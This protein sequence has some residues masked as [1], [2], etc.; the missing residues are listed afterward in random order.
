MFLLGRNCDRRVYRMSHCSS[1]S[2]LLPLFFFPEKCTALT[3]D[4]CASFPRV[5]HIKLFPLVD[6]LAPF[7]DL[8][9]F[10]SLFRPECP[11]GSTSPT[12]LILLLGGDDSAVYPRRSF[13]P[14]T[15]PVRRF[16]SP[17][18]YRGLIFLHFK[19]LRGTAFF[20][21]FVCNYHFH[22]S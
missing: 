4:T 5:G 12:P 19:L 8:S 2:F 22:S 18:F 13:P 14:G 20:S 11:L 3:G 1:L 10:I 17:I 15:R 7:I 9:V 6:L 21:A 16:F